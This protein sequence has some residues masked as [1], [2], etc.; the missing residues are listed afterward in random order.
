MYSIDKRMLENW[1]HIIF[2][3]QLILLKTAWL[4]YNS[5]TKEV[6]HLKYTSQWFSV[7]SVVQPLLQSNFRT[8]YHSLKKKKTKKNTHSSSH[9]VIS[10]HPHSSSSRPGA[11]LC[12][13][14]TDLPVL[15]A[16]SNICILLLKN[17]LL[18]LLFAMPYSMHDLSSL[19]RDWTQV[20]CSGSMESYLLDRQGCPSQLVILNRKFKTIQLV[21]VVAN[22]KKHF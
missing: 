10:C 22:Y 2:Y 13:V 5:H 6:T 1:W 14:S 3:S 15:P 21:S 4:Q 12:S 19:T 16:I 18:L 17:F 9:P 20:P 7:Y 11:N 8:F